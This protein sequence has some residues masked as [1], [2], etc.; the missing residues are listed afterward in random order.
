MQMYFY[1]S[2][3]SLLCE[4]YLTYSCVVY[5]KNALIHC[6]WPSHN[7]FLWYSWFFFR[8]SLTLVFWI[9]LRKLTNI[10]SIF[11]ISQTWDDPCS[12]YLSSRKAMTRPAPFIPFLQMAWLSTAMVHYDDVIMGAIA[13]QI[14]SLA[15]VYSI[16]YSGADQSKHQSSTSL[17]FVRGIHRDR[18]IPRTNGQ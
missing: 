13:S 17:A 8:M 12:L 6:I 15:I 2:S 4:A 5:H 11:I 1:I 9:Y 14:T 3:N 10:F 7:S 18:W 16:V